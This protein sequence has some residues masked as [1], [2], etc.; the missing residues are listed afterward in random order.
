[1][2]VDHRR[3]LAVVAHPRHQILDPRPARRGE[4]VTGVPEIMKV[5]PS[6]PIDLT[7]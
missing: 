4:R 2:L 3:P 5:Q 6:A 1:V 7:A